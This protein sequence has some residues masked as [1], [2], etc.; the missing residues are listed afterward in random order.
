MS[1]NITSPLP[2]SMT[3]YPRVLPMD[4]GRCLPA[5]AQALA[6]QAGLSEAQAEG[7]DFINS[8][9]DGKR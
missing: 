1:G 9:G 6:G 3:R 5:G 7:L 4:K 8:T 2:V